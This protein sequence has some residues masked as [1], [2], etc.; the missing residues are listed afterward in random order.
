MMSLALSSLSLL[1][2]ESASIFCKSLI[3]HVHSGRG[4]PCARE[5]LIQLGHLLPEA[6]VSECSLVTTPFLP[7]KV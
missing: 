2:R 1:L 5:L 7:E 3:L 4:L 6:P